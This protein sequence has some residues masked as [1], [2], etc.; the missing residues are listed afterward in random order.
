MLWTG[1]CPESCEECLEVEFESGEKDTA[2]LNPLYDDN[3]CLFGGNFMGKETKAGQIVVSSSE[4]LKTGN[5]DDIEVSFMDER[6]PVAKMF[7][8]NLGSGVATAEFNTYRPN[9]V[10]MKM[11]F[12]HENEESSEYQKTNVTMRQTPSFPTNGFSLNLALRYDNEF[13]NQ[14]GS[15]AENT[16]QNIMAHVQNHFQWDSLDANMCFN[17]ESI[18]QSDINIGGNIN[19]NSLVNH[20]LN[21]E[22]TE[23]PNLFVYL[24]YYTPTG[25]TY[26]A[27]SAWVG[28]V[29]FSDNAGV[30]GGSQNG[31]GFRA[32][33]SLRTYKGD[34]D[35]AEIVSHEIGHNLGMQH[36]FNDDEGVDSNRF[37]ETDTSYNCKNQGGIMDYFQP[38]TTTW[39]CCSNSDFL[40]YYESRQPFCLSACP[41]SA[42]TTP[43]PAPTTPPPA[44]TSPPTAPT[45]QPPV[46]I[47][48]MKP[49]TTQSPQDCMDIGSKKWCKKQKNKNRCKKL[50]IYN[51]CMKTCDCTP[52]SPEECKDKKSAEFCMKK[53]Q[54]NRCHKKRNKKR[55]K[56]TCGY[57]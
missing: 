54:R 44:P 43:P 28:S 53:K 6:S 10:V 26:T 37:C 40:N 31:K 9:E 20:I 15:T 34:L 23:S 29:C 46:T 57:C 8:A 5:M 49:P 12:P 39:T 56:K 4:C 52:P 36:D 41:T 51:Q 35:C 1:N 19:M 13:A 24:S 38:T 27:G 11:L 21:T 18:E 3:D 48:T 32:S 7:K 14:F 22:Q 33:V 42:P 55:C 50:H 25:G 2:C 17:I 30:N 16:V 47:V 45:T